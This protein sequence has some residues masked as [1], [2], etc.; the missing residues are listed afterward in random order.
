MTNA[1][2]SIL[3]SDVPD[4]VEIEDTTTPRVPMSSPTAFATVGDPVPEM[5]SPMKES[6]FERENI[7]AVEDA[8]YEFV[9]HESADSAAMVSSETT[10]PMSVDK[11][12]ELESVKA[13]RQSSAKAPLQESQQAN[14]MQTDAKEQ[15]D[16]EMVDIKVPSRHE[17]PPPIPPR[18]VQRRKSTWQPLKYG[19]QQDVTECITNCLSQLHAAFKPEEI[20]ANGDHIDLFKK[21][22][23]CMNVTN[24]GYFTSVFEKNFEISRPA[25]LR[26]Q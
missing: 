8:D 25:P 3:D 2:Q 11:E 17:T 10:D 23:P 24:L 14:I 18:P 4:L 1:S 9:D 6:G 19:S 22:A 16:V 20:A 15:D 5:D 21:Y 12:N 26:N 13:R 7:V